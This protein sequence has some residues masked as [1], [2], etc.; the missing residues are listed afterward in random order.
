MSSLPFRRTKFSYS[1]WEIVDTIFELGN[2]E[3]T[4]E[5]YYYLFFE[6]SFKRRERKNYSFHFACHSN[7][8]SRDWI[9]IIRLSFGWRLVNMI[10]VKNGAKLWHSSFDTCSKKKK[11]EKDKI[12][13]S[14]ENINMK[15]HQC[16]LWSVISL[17][18]GKLITYKYLRKLWKGV[19]I[20]ETF[21]SWLTL[22]R[23]LHTKNLFSKIIESSMWND[24]RK[25]LFKE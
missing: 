23:F 10:V 18:D 20:I 2:F 12:F 13:E 6:N 17:I 11:K 19:F 7:F 5:W 24:F 14:H 1:R 15:N 25:N 16:A 4:I 8:M 22:S 9:K 3:L 21:F